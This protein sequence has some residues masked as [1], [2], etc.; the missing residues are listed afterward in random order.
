MKSYIP[1]LARLGSAAL[2]PDGTTQDCVAK[3]SPA[4]VNDVCAM[5]VAD[6]C[7]ILRYITKAGLG[8][9]L[10]EDFVD[11]DGWLFA[12]RV[13]PISS[14]TYLTTTEWSE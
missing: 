8:G 6:D 12:T 4:A 3:A 1:T 10:P 9:K 11:A 13:V 7:L 5:K 14:V 2:H